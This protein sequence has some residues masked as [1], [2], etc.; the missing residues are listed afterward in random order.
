MAS[1]TVPESDFLLSFDLDPTAYPEQQRIARELHEASGASVMF[2]PMHGGRS[3]KEHLYFV[4]ADYE[5]SSFFIDDRK[6]E[7]LREQLIDGLQEV[8]FECERQVR[9][10]EALTEAEWI[11][12]F[13]DPELPRRILIKDG[14]TVVDVYDAECLYEAQVFMEEWKRLDQASPTG[15]VATIENAGDAGKAVTA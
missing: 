3:G 10:L 5:C 7:S 12:E 8:A 9:R 4:T 11:A 13:G 15:C 1:A 6:P 2:A 14:D